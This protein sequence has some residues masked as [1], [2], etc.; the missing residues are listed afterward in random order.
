MAAELIGRC[1]CPVCHGRARL[2]LARTQ[3]SVLTCNGC[4][5]QGFARS[6]RSDGLLRGLLVAS[7]EPT[8]DPVRTAPA[9]EPV[10]TAP[11]APKPKPEP[12]QGWGAFPWLK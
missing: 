4:N 5:F 11:A 8:P 3:L 2:T 9:P 1:T 7:D 6:D 12:V 10:R